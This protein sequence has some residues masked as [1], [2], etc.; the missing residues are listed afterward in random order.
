MGKFNLESVS[1]F[2][3]VSETNGGVR[4]LIVDHEQGIV[5]TDYYLHNGGHRPCKMVKL[6]ELKRLENYYINFLG[7]K[8]ID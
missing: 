6:K 8:N 7:Y 2:K 1:E 5:S 3:F 4:Y